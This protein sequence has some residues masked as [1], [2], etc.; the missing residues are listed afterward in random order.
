MRC[1]AWM[2]L[3]GGAASVTAAPATDEGGG[4]AT[5]WAPELLLMGIGDGGRGGRVGIVGSDCALTF[6]DHVGIDDDDGVSIDSDNSVDHDVR[7]RA[8]SLMARGVFHQSQ[9]SFSRPLADEEGEIQNPDGYVRF[10][11]VI[12][13]RVRRI[14]SW[15]D[16]RIVR[17]VAPKVQG[18]L[19]GYDELEPGE[20]RECDEE[21]TCY[22]ITKSEN[23]FVLASG[24]LNPEFGRHNKLELVK[25]HVPLEVTFVPHHLEMTPGRLDEM[26][27]SDPKEPGVTAKTATLR[28]KN[29]MSPEFNRP[30]WKISQEKSE[31]LRNIG[32]CDARSAETQLHGAQLVSNEIKACEYDGSGTS[33]FDNLG[34]NTLAKFIIKP[35]A[36][37]SNETQQFVILIK[38]VLYL[39]VFKSRLALVLYHA[40]TQCSHAAACFKVEEK[41]GGKFTAV[42]KFGYCIT[43]QITV[44]LLCPDYTGPE[45]AVNAIRDYF[46]EAEFGGNSGGVND[47]PSMTQS[48]FEQKRCSIIEVIRNRSAAETAE[49]AEKR[50]AALRQSL[51][52]RRLV[53]HQSQV[54]FSRPL[55]DEEGELQNPDGDLRFASV[56]FR[57]VRRIASWVDTR[58]VRQVPVKVQENLRGYDELEPGER[59]ECDEQV[60]CYTI[61]NSESAFV[62]ASGA[63]NPEFGRHNKLELVKNHVPFE[64][65]FVPHHLEMTPASL[66]EML[67]SDQNE[68]GVTAKTATSRLKMSKSPEF[69]RP[70]WRR[71]QEKSEILRNIGRC[72]ARSAETQLHGA[73]LVSNEIKA[74]EYDG[75]GT[76]HFDNLSSNTLAK[77]IIKPLADSSNETQ[78]LAILIKNVLYLFVFKSRLALVLYHALTLCP[79]AS[80]CFKVEEKDGGKF[81]A[82]PKF[83]YCI[84]VQITV[85]LLR[86][87]YTG[88]AVNAIRDY[89]G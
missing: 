71:S 45:S 29:S 38:N 3:M 66:D 60:T 87:D 50:A 21:V 88:S 61:T 14:K 41:D 20:R 83:G 32:R 37:S 4:M 33:H 36:D 31:I 85:G 12:F 67:D 25:N 13:R 63:L 75:S 30:A 40:L 10:A 70:A 53:S 76:S 42:P 57:R 5:T 86:P 51:M 44:G 49:T 15:L 58:I 23:T 64:V 16:T 19:R 69:D 11:S 80:V 46:G 81:T 34:S 17:R 28:L 48:D 26:L 82:V 2:M 54:S 24:A 74:C 68:P 39:F 55:A 73:Q 27:D 22:T 72:D 8:L 1:S 56:I 6:H 43:V 7:Q 78:Q 9:V 77:F 47:P 52:A 79:H 59:R 84:T 89:F 62:L 18:N 65:T 35:L